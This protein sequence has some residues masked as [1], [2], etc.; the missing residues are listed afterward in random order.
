[1]DKRYKVNLL[2]D[3]SGRL[4]YSD[5]ETLDDDITVVAGVIIDPYDLQKFSKVVYKIL[6]SISLDV[7]DSNG[8]I[9]ITDLPPNKMEYLREQIFNAIETFQLPLVFTSL[10]SKKIHD[11]Y[12]KNVKEHDLLVASQAIK[13]IS[14]NSNKTRFVESYQVQAF[15]YTYIKAVIFCLKNLNIPVE[16][17]VVTDRIDEEIVRLYKEK[18]NEFH[19]IGNDK[20]MRG[21]RYIKGT[22]VVQKYE[23]TVKSAINDPM[24]SLIKNSIGFLTQEPIVHSIVADVVANSV[25]YYLKESIA[26]VSNGKF[27][28]LEAIKKHPLYER[29]IYKE[30][31]CIYY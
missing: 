7:A 25:H 21:S 19:D 4:G 14:L 27:D 10:L 23:V 30:K 16:L 31:A 6:D 24:D 3:E 29:F 18:I 11:K 15:N 9:H 5:K 13:G 12:S 20:P 8:K 17:E 22:G 1:M 26:S 2:I 28:E